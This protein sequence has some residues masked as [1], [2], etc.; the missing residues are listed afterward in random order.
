LSPRSSRRTPAACKEP[1]QSRKTT[2]A[3]VAVKMYFFSPLSMLTS[4]RQL[5]LL[6]ASRKRDPLRRRNGRNAAI[7]K[8]QGRQTPD[9]GLS[10][11]QHQL[12]LSFYHI[13]TSRY[14]PQ[15]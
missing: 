5:H 14:F 15:A 10:Q 11:Q 2:P 3:K 1:Q 8:R 6:F 4:I 13:E 7:L 12:S 9:K